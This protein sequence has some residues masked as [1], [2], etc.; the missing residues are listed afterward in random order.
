MSQ[1]AADRADID[2]LHDQLEKQVMELAARHNA[3]VAAAENVI[4]EYPIAA[5]KIRLV[6]EQY[7]T[8]DYGYGSIK[9]LR[10]IL[11]QMK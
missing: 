9:A 5:G 6:G 4:K 7:K 11:E 1:P 2:E 3:L 8:N 10:V